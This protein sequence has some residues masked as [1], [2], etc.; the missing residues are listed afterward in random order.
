MMEQR[1]QPTIEQLT[2]LMDNNGD[3]TRRFEKELSLFVEDLIDPS[4]L[5]ALMA[6]EELNTRYLGFYGLFI[7]CRRLMQYERLKAL[8]DRHTVVFSDFISFGHLHTMYHID[9][10]EDFTATELKEHLTEAAG[11]VDKY[12]RLD[13]GGQEVNLA[14]VQHAFADLLITC[15]ERDEKNCGALLEE[16]GRKAERALEDA[17]SLSGG[18]AKYYC[19]KGRLQALRHEYDQAAASVRRA[20]SLE[21][22]G[23]D[24][25]RYSLRMMQ[26]QSHLVRIQ[27]R[28]E[29]H[30]LKQ[31]QQRMTGEVERIRGAL[32]SN[33]EIIAFFSGIISFVI[34]SLNLVEAF[35]PAQAAGLI[36]VLLGALLVV[37][38]CFALLLHME[39]RPGAARIVVFVVGLICIVGGLLLVR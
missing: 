30:R 39:K 35:A 14:G 10:G 20:I 28:S 25:S 27:T 23:K 38:N 13:L 7:Y 17:I 21:P 26:Y 2:A 9:S 16:W 32:L 31:E 34:G 37:F 12:R 18:Y 11:V 5:E 15:C 22:Q 3:C 33:V 19:T 36:V 4:A 8:F 1:Q 6:T 29:V 24:A